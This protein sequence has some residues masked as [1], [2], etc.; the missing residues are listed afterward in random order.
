MQVDLDAK[1]H[2]LAQDLS[3]LKCDS[4]GKE[5]ICNA[6]ASEINEYLPNLDAEFNSPKLEELK[7]NGIV[8]LDV[9]LT[10]AQLLDVVSY[11]SAI[12][13]FGGHVPAQSDGIRRF[14]HGGAKASPFGSYATE[15]LVQCPHLLEL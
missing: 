1:L 13:V 4:H 3:E 7:T 9:K 8:R 14:L 2:A 12:P 6:I 5:A 11:L 15:D 10:E